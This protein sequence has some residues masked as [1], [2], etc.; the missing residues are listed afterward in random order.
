MVKN[1][2]AR[3][4]FRRFPDIKEDLWGG[5]FRRDGGYVGTVGDEVTAKVIENYI[6]H[7]G[8]KQEKIDYK[9]FKLYHLK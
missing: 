5:E 6:Q 1:I 3:E 2:S 8:S 9:Q 4:L 7:Q